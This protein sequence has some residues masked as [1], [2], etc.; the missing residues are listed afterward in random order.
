[1]KSLRSRLALSAATAITFTSFA[2]T[3]EKKDAPP[4]PAAPPPSPCPQLVLNAPGGRILK[5]GETVSVSANLAGGDGSASPNFVWTTSAG[6]IASG[7][8]TRN[9]SIDST[10][11][12]GDR[13]INIDLWV[14][15]YAP[16]CSLQAN[17][18]LKVVPPAHK[19][20]E[21]G[22]LE[23]ER[24]AELLNSF[25][26]NLSGNSDNVYV[27]GYAGRSNVRGYAS[28]ILKRIKSGLVAKGMNYQ[29]LGFIDGG[30]REVPAFEIWLVPVGADVPR[31]TPTIAAKDIVFPKTAPTAPA[32]KP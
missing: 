12:G 6:V 4:A 22:E 13:Q 29:R 2:F 14:S 24:E 32:K 5:D 8:G 28:G 19:A 9:V 27:F 21:F 15:G 23:P 3:Q 18:M 1:M 10:G 30:Y 11:A 7:Q 20:L 17:A 16:E 25:V 26:E 31:S